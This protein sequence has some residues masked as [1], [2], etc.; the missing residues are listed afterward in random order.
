MR[1][2]SVQIRETTR[3]HVGSGRNRQWFTSCDSA[4]ILLVF[5]VAFAI[6]SSAFAQTPVLTSHN[7]NGRS[8]A[9]TNETLLSPSDV[10]KN[11][12]VDGFYTGIAR[13]TDLCYR[14]LSS[15][16]TGRVRWYV[17]GM[18]AGSVLFIAM[19]LYL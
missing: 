7:D 19:V 5:A 4:A 14:G 10:N 18:A 11:D 15:T 16:Q 9:N 2:F 6:A 17:T 3:V 12:F 13:L 8:A 1:T